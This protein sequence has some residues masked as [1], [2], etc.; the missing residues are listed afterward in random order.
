MLRS[1]KEGLTER[2]SAGQPAL[3]RQEVLPLSTLSSVM[4]ARFT[5]LFL[6]LGDLDLTPIFLYMSELCALQDQENF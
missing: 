4:A 2:F 5:F 3:H 6:R 1:P